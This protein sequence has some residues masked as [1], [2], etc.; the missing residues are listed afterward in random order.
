MELRID[1]QKR[2]LKDHGTYG[3]PVNISRKRL[4]SYATGTFPWHWHDEIELTLILEGEMEYRVND[5]RYRLKAGEGLFCNSDALHAGAMA[6]GQ[7]CDYVSLTFHPRLLYGFEG[8][9]IGGKY[10]DGLVKSQALSSARL[11][12]EVLWQREILEQIA[13]VYQA[14]QE[15]NDFY[16]MEVFRRLL[17][18]WE[19]LYRH[20]REKAGQAPA[21]DP[22]K[23]RRLRTILSFLHEHYRE[24]ITLEE[25]ARQINLCKSECCRLFKRQMGLS[26]F[27]YL[28]EYRVG[29]S[30]SILKE[31][32]TVEEAARESGFSS[33]A[34]FAKVFRAR[35]GRSPSQYRKETRNAGESGLLLETK[36]CNGI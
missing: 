12:P 10:V 20:Y 5:S 27:D 21:E 28:L 30:L 4:S 29:R 25:A 18:V 34:Y 6:E 31:G 7:D 33:A 19:E 1:E 23:L 14:S 35:T 16:E 36:E 3:F 22:E 24:K 15:K 17:A 11:S 9:V 8:S 2:E 26:L 32:G 13:A